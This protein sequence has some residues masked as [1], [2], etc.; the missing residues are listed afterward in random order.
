MR[1]STSSAKKI[2]ETL[3]K[4]RPTNDVHTFLLFQGK[5]N[6]GILIKFTIIA[7]QIP[8]IFMNVSGNQ[9]KTTKADPAPAHRARAPLFENFLIF[10]TPKHA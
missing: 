1:T 7:D 10:S 5:T 2:L 3:H 4:I 8:D 6:V 9:H